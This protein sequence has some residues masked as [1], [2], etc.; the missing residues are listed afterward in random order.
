LFESAGLTPIG[1]FGFELHTSLEVRVKK[2]AMSDFHQLGE[3]A[4]ASSGL[5]FGTLAHVSLI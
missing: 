3:F 1:R 2:L 5:R 4:V